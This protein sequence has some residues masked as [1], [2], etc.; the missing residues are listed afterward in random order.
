[1]SYILI[2]YV[3]AYLQMWFYNRSSWSLFLRL[4]QLREE[5]TRLL[6]AT[7]NYLPL[8]TGKLL[9][10]NN[11]LIV[12]VNTSISSGHMWESQ[13]LLTDGQVVFLRVL[14]FSPTFDEQSARHKW[15]ILERAVKPKSK[16]K[17]KKKKKKRIP[18]SVSLFKP[19][20]KSLEDLELFN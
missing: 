6:S 11:S 14:R 13:V 2:T 18:V 10:G 16:K 15:N 1:M 5:H 7:R 3:K 17:K 8:N 9:F 19:I 12:Q 4:F 20:L